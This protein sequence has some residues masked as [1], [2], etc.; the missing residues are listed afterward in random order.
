MTH[1]DLLIL[2]LVTAWGLSVYLRDCFTHFGLALV[3]ITFPVSLP[4]LMVWIW[5]LQAK[6]EF[7]SL[8]DA[9]R[10]KE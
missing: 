10:G 4:V 2:Y 9:T 6:G 3:S 1:T 5:W 8:K 7:K